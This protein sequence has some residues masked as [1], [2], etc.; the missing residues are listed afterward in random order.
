MKVHF[1]LKEIRKLNL[2]FK[3]IYAA[4]VPLLLMKFLKIFRILYGMVDFNKTQFL[5]GMKKFYNLISM[6]LKMTIA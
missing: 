1:K 6:S 3:N 5:R 2:N 4:I